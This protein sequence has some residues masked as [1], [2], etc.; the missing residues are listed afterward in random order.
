MKVFFDKLAKLEINDAVG[1]YDIEIKGLG[2]R[3]KSE[4]KAG[5]RR[6]REYPYA[7]PKEKDDLRRHLL[8]KFPYKIIYSIEKDYI[9]VIAVAHCHRRP[10]Y[11][12]DRMLA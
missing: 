1:F 3:F 5:I 9:Y 10:D 11:W 2:K 6:I 4:V 12:I 7:W 8:H